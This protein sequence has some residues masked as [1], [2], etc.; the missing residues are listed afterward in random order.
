M[1]T[2]EESGAGYPEE[3]PSEV[4][5]TPGQRD[6]EQDPSGGDEERA[7]DN[8]DGT[9]TGNPNAAGGSRRRDP[10]RED[11]DVVAR[12][13]RRG[14]QRGLG[15]GVDQLLRVAARAAGDDLDE[16]VRRPHAVRR[17][18]LGHAVGVEQDGVAGQQLGVTSS[19]FGS[20]TSP[21][22]VPL[23]S[24]SSTRPSARTTIGD[25]W[26]PTATV[27]SLRPAERS[28]CAIAT[29]Q[30]RVELSR[31]ITS[32]TQ[33]RIAAGEWRRAAAARIV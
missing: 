14:P 21:S 7:P 6:P 10:Q 15:D 32:L 22:S 19:S 18:R 30:K 24:S 26:P 23:P 16:I 33:R 13:R 2:P 12:R 17:P 1:E 3:Q 20:S 31:T 5:D 28:R 27:R 9:A 11:R 29:V 4:D 25:G 8:E